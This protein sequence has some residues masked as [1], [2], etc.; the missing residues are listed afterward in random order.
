MREGRVEAEVEEGGK[1]KRRGSEGKEEGEGEGGREVGRELP[2]QG[3]D[4]FR[5][6]TSAL[7]MALVRYHHVPIVYLTTRP[8]KS[9]LYVFCRGEALLDSML[10]VLVL[11]WLDRA[12]S[13]PRS[14]T[15]EMSAV[16]SKPPP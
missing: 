5:P 10:E 14:E 8:T 7:L 1:G 15:E 11:T 2:R 3:G 6:L 13:V 12:W 4:K 16:L 9:A